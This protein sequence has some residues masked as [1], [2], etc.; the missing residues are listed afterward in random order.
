MHWMLALSS[1]TAVNR[2]LGVSQNQ[3]LVNCLVG[4]VLPMLVALV[5]NKVAGANVKAAILLV[6]G[7]IGAALSQ[8]TVD[9]FQWKA[10]GVTL[11][12][13]LLTAIASHYGL[14]K[15]LGVTGST[16]AI[17]N[18]VPGGLRGGSDPAPSPQ[19]VPVRPAVPADSTPD[20][21]PPP[22]AS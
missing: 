2:G 5:T 22:A 14:L 8:T 18:A 1:P 6:L 21:T 12:T 4:V 15:P 13:Q 7:V 17:Q 20:G 10:F 11:V 3:F 16:G 9:G 19:A